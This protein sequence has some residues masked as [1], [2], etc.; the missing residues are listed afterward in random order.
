[1]QD[2]SA[3]M[4]IFTFHGERLGG[5]MTYYNFAILAWVL[6][7]KSPLYWG[8]NFTNMYFPIMLWAFGLVH[9]W[10]LRLDL[11]NPRVMT[12]ASTV[13]LLVFFATTK[14]VNEAYAMWAIPA[15]L[16]ISMYDRRAK[17]P[18]YLIT[19]LPLFYLAINTPWPNFF[20]LF[21]LDTWV[22]NSPIGFMFL[23]PVKKF[24]IL[25]MLGT[26]FSLLS[27]TTAVLLVWKTPRRNQQDADEKPDEVRPAEHIVIP[28]S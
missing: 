14:L 16:L 5:G 9:L 24:S 18:F 23:D 13:V 17:L 1:V 25:F 22:L 15:L 3:F 21:I 8:L 2:I 19:A 10:V 20:R 6:W 28:A 4:N 26:G 12:A 7:G 27:I 11:R